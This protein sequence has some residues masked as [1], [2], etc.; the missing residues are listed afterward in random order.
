MRAAGYT[1]DQV[2]EAFITILD[3]LGGWSAGLPAGFGA[4]Y[5]CK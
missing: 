5:L 3:N 4:L 2:Y 1:L